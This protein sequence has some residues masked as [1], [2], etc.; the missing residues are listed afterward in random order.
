MVYPLIDNLINCPK[1]F[2]SRE[3]KVSIVELG[4]E[5]PK[6]GFSDLIYFIVFMYLSNLGEILQVLQ[7]FLSFKFRIFGKGF[8]NCWSDKR[9]NEIQ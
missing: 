4:Y 1:H 2:R 3:Q 9:Y 5:V 6:L 8:N 7:Y